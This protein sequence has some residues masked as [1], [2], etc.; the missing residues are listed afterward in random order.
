MEYPIRRTLL[1]EIGGLDNASTCLT[2]DIAISKMTMFI[3]PLLGGILMHKVGLQ[4]FYFLA[5]ISL[6]LTLIFVSKIKVT[7]PALKTHKNQIF[8]SIRDGLIQARDNKSVLGV[9]LITII[10]NFFGYS[11]ISMVPVIGASKLDLSPVSIGF[12]SS[13]LGAGA[14]INLLILAVCAKPNFFMRYFLGG[15]LT[16]LVTIVFFSITPW[17]GIALAVLFLGGLGEAGFSS[18]QATIAFTTTSPE[19]RSRIMGLIVVCIGFGPIGVLHTGLMANWLGADIAIGV[20]A[21]EGLITTLICLWLI[22][23]LRRPGVV[24]FNDN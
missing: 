24:I 19:A 18:M 5:T 13:M 10:L 8:S 22:P 21:L 4:G 12:L 7:T 11:F 15:T 2:F 3:G 16:L 1:G 9:L 17:F 6:G 20:I 23:A 14:L